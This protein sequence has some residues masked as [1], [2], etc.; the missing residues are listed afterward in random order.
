MTL[1]SSP[2]ILFH[3]GNGAPQYLCLDTAQSLAP[4][5]HL[6]NLPSLICSGTQPILLFS[7]NNLSLIAGTFTNQDD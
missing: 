5:S 1:I 4:S 2:S 3:I 7:D 6:P